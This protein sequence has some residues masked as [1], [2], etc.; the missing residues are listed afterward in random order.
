[1]RKKELAQSTGN[2]L[3]LFGSELRMLFLE[4]VVEPL[5]EMVVFYVFRPFPGKPGRSEYDE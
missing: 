5:G 4:L 1:M 3:E 2:E